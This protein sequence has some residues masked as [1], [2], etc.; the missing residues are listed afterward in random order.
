MTTREKG[1]ENG[2]LRLE[3][4]HLFAVVSP[5]DLARRL[6]T[7]VGELE[8]LANGTD[9]YKLWKTDAGRDVEEP[10]ADLQR[11]HSRVHRYLARVAPPDFLHSPVK[12]R[13]Y[14]TNARAHA[15]DGPSIK[16]DIRRFFQSVPRV[17]VYLFFKEDMKCAGDV[18][19]L[20]AKLL[21]YN[22]HLPTG[23]SASPIIAYYAFRSMFS[24]I[25]D[26]ARR[27][28]LV[29]TAYVDDITVTG[30][31]D[32]GQAI[33]EIQSIISQRGLRSH[34]IKIFPKGRPKIITGVVVDG[35]GIKL[36]NRRHKLISDKFLEL[37]RVTTPEEE[38][39][40]LNQLI[41]RLHEA[42]MIEPAFKARA[43]TLERRRTDTR[44]LV[45][46]L[47]AT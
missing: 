15:V 11:I 35:E 24:E 30:A 1:V 31:S 38:L 40:I 33:R 13:S 45:S 10:R 32:C 36:P 43:R 19:G 5:A 3:D 21:T 16:I 47:G 28:N 27:Q 14:V 37:S 6:G 4:C 34:K 12:G 25:A 8:R 20:L 22:G 39:Q 29:V 2:M 17:A 46:A 44:Q 26:L 9:T 41:S 7:S 23:G 42:G 18:A